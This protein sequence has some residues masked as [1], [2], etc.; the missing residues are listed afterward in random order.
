MQVHLYLNSDVVTVVA[1]RPCLYPLDDCL[2]L[3]ARG[4]A[5]YL[6]AHSSNWRSEIQS[7]RETVAAR[8]SGLRLEESKDY[9]TRRRQRCQENTGVEPQ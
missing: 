3:N 5:H 9:S 1:A 8:Y 4:E 2:L 7:V 6:V